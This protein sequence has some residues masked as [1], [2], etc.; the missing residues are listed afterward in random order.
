[1][2]V[3]TDKLS[4]AEKLILAEE[5][6]DSVLGVAGDA[7]I[8]DAERRIL[9]DELSDLAQDPGAGSSWTDVKD[10]IQR[11]IRG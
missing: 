2:L 10:R 6:W 7:G 9:E 1:M 4:V 3:D 8:S 11:T 5:L